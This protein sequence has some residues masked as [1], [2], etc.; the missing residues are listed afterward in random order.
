M[1]ISTDL[2]SLSAMLLEFRAMMDRLEAMLG[3][4]EDAALTDR[5]QEITDA[6][7][8]SNTYSQQIV[9]NL[10]DALM[11]QQ[12]LKRMAAQIDAIHKN[13]AL[14]TQWLGETLEKAR[15]DG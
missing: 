11:Q 6:I 5:L 9:E 8:A 12:D 1:T 14:M 3:R 10:T 7:V 2:Q 15:E 4:S 13:Q